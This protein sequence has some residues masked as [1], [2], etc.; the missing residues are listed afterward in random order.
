MRVRC[1]RGSAPSA[2]TP[3]AHPLTPSH[4]SLAPRGAR[5]DKRRVNAGG[6]GLQR[7]SAAAA[8]VRAASACLR[9]Q[10]LLDQHLEPPLGQQQVGGQPGLRAGRAAGRA[11]SLE[12]SSRGRARREPLRAHETEREGLRLRNECASRKAL[13]GPA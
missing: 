12:L 7:S 6:A 1:R 4:V 8:R 10:S 13:E 11:R 9:L 3:H 5:G 2:G